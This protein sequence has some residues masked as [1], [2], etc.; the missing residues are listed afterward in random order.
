MTLK[1][2]IKALVHYDLI[3]KLKDILLDFSGNLDN[4]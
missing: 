2:K 4:T 1:E 3:A